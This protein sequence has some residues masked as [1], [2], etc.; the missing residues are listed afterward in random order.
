[1]HKARSLAAGSVARFMKSPFVRQTLSSL[2]QPEC[3]TEDLKISA[4]DGRPV[5]IR[6]YKPASVTAS[7][8]PVLVIAHSGGFCTGGLETEEF[9]CRVL[10]RSLDL[11]VVDI[12]YRLAPE[13]KFPSAV[14]DV[15]GVVKWVSQN[16]ASF[17]GDLSKG[18]ILAGVSAG[19]N[20]TVH[21]AYMA[22][23][24]RLTPPLTGTMFICTGMP[25][26]MYDPHS[27]RLDLFPGKLVSWEENK[28]APISSRETNKYY[29]GEFNNVALRTRR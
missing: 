3:Q 27:G 7:R 2:R 23:D 25:H 5:P 24:E 12:D 9:I 18:F 21:A 1:M 8:K 14:F 11:I 15:Y 20:Y 4:T 29:R 13:F 19:G 26:D 16:A 28:D 17:G 10:C 22:R 6:I